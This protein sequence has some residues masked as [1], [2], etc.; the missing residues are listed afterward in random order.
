LIESHEILGRFC[1]SKFVVWDI[2]VG[3]PVVGIGD[4]REERLEGMRFRGS[5]ERLH[6]E[7]RDEVRTFLL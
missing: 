3:I 6:G 2:D 4:G 1:Q 5:E 7:T